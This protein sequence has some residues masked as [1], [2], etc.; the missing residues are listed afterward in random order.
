MYRSSNSFYDCYS[1]TVCDCSECM[2]LEGY[3]AM[4]KFDKVVEKKR[5]KI[6]QEKRKLKRGGF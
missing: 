4:A 3:D 2:E 1:D 5:K 6:L